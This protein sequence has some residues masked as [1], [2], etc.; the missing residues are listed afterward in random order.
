[1]N[2]MTNNLTIDEKKEALYVYYFELF[3]DNGLDSSIAV[4]VAKRV[5]NYTEIEV[6]KLYKE[7]F[8]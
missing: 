8:Q 3:T 1:M 5:F 4:S 6:D 7:I 2:I